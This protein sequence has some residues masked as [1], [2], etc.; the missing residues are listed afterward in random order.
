MGNSHEE[1]EEFALGPHKDLVCQLVQGPQTQTSLVVDIR[2]YRCVVGAHQ[3][4]TIY[5][6]HCK[7]V[8]DVVEYVDALESQRSQSSIHTLR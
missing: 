3:H 4:M 1:W 2:D 7:H 8:F 5:S 6:K